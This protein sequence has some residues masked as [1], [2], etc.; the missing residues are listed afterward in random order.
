M[1]S[2]RRKCALAVLAAA[3]GVQAGTAVAADCAVDAYDAYVYATQKATPPFDRTLYFTCRAAHWNDAEQVRFE[4]DA[5]GGLICAGSTGDTNAGP[6]S[7]TA[8]LFATPGASIWT[9][10][11]W[12]VTGYDLAGGPVTKIR[13]RDSMIAFDFEVP[14]HGTQFRYQVKSITFS[15]PGGQCGNVLA[16]AFGWS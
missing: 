5:G 2:L 7:V 1:N 13:R 3:F 10:N 6:V 8:E 9:E 12:H 4:A 15:K 16:E 11:G 14:G